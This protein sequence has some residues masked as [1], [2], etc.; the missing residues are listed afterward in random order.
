MIQ[1]KIMKEM[2]KIRVIQM[3]MM[4]KNIKKKKEEKN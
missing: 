1:L 2:I 3:K 4:M